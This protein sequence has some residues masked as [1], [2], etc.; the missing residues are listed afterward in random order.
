MKEYGEQ[1]CY[2]KKSQLPHIEIGII[3]GVEALFITLTKK[4]N[5]NMS[6]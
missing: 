2:L 6:T 4:G 3:I 5:P 1:S